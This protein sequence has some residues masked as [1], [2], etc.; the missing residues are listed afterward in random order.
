[1]SIFKTEQ[2]LERERIHSMLTP[3]RGAKQKPSAA[4][5]DAVIKYFKLCGGEAYRINTV[6]VYDE[7]MGGLRSSG[8]KKGLPD[9]IGIYKG[10]FIGVEIKI[11]K[12][13]QSEDQKNREQEIYLAGGVYLI[14]KTF[15]Q[16]KPLLD[17]IFYPKV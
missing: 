14:A 17:E 5:T 9:V 2:E 16:I 7:K 11:G 12:D 6:G 10:R 15:D 4:L 1:M 8:M 3:K 13:R